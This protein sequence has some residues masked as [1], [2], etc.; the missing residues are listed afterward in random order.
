MKNK[1]LYNQKNK[2]ELIK[3]IN[4]EPFKRV[5]CSFYKY[6]PMDKLKELRD[7]LYLKW[8]AL[9][10]L[11]RIYIANEGINAQMSIPEHSIDAFKSQL[12]SY[13]KFRGTP[14]KIAIYEGLSF[15]KLTIKIK[16]EIV[17]YKI[18]E[19][20]YDMSKTGEHLNYQEFNKAIDEGA[21]VIDMRNYYESQIGKF[22]NAVIPD[23]ETSME[24]LPEIKKMLK[25]EK[26]E[27][28]LMY[29]TGGIRCEK[30]SAYL[31]YHGFTDVNQL[32]GGI[33]QYANDS[34]KDNVP[35]KFIGKNFVFDR[36]LGEK[37]TD[38]I[39]GFCHQCDAP[40]DSHTNCINQ[41]CHIL[42]IQC[43]KCAKKY[44]RCCSKVCSDFIKL[45]K[46][47]QKVLFKKGAVKF[48]AQK[49]SK[50]KPKLYTI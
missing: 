31:I 16:N 4:N 15:L 8:N 11:G 10:I 41:A 29:C 30:A 48:T 26:N 21:T 14:L 7:E 3:H 46:E 2:N 6:I 32:K 42:F 12:F 5:T 19:N 36:R 27:K 34:K 50:I 17:A 24:L 35:S 38:D 25:N 49:S 28:I 40:E 1:Y 23:V 37:I 18:P 45:P 43:K 33:I 13:E 20:E 9:G 44:S 47:E 22:K 39:I